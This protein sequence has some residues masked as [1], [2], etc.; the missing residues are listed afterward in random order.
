LAKASEQFRQS[1]VLRWGIVALVMGGVAVL[2]SNVSALIPQSML[3]GLHKSRLQG[4]TLDQMRVQLADLEEETLALRRDNA[5]L[6]ARFTLR[7]QDANEVTR[8]VG[9]LEVSVPRLLEDLPQPVAIDRTETGS[10]GDEGAQTFDAEGGS[11]VVRQRPMDIALPAL[12]ADASVPTAGDGLSSYGVAVGPPVSPE[13]ASA[14]WRDLSVKLGPL[15]LGLTPTTID[16]DDGEGERLVAG[17]IA[18]LSEATALCQRL[19]RVSI[20][21]LPVPY[22]GTPVATP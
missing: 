9:A 8:R 13:Q 21:C 6:A 5:A 20:P 4:A 22:G 3:A 10:I 7:E 15:L 19:E 2:G 16:I 17:P 14:T 12:P 11:V 18:Q 1:D